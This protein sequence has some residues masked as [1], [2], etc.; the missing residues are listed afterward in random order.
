M[1]II[2]EPLPK[3][4]F[5]VAPRGYARDHEMTLEEIGLMTILYTL[6]KNWVYTAVGF[7]KIVP[8]G[9]NRISRL[10][11]LLT[12]RGY[13]EVV[14]EKKA[15]GKYSGKTIKI[16][17]YAN[18]FKPSKKNAKMPVPQLPSPCFE[19]T[20]SEA[21]YNNKEINTH[22]NNNNLSINLSSDKIDEMREDIK[23]Q[24]SYD[25]AC[26][27]FGKDRVDGVI[28]IMMEIF[29]SVDTINM[30]KNTIPAEQVKNV[31]RKIDVD[32]LRYVFDCLEETSK[33]KPIKNMKSYL[34]TALYNAPMTI[35]TYYQ[36]EVNYDQYG[37]KEE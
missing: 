31:F 22:Q 15:D 24:I 25:Y 11:R 9:K 34:K 4:D 1:P 30:G 18:G 33:N 20:V 2:K 27:E 10:M 7:S 23:E 29:L 14:Q 17:N 13:V 35:D 3:N 12:E 19:S 6:P 16:K 37:R 26:R 32:H 21:Q 5:F 28:D 36:A 8:H